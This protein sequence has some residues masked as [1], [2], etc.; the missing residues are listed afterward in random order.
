MEYILPII[1]ILIL[2]VAIIGGGLYIVFL[3][4]KFLRLK[5]KE[6]EGRDK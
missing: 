5:I 3:L 6:M 1:A 2:N 4:I